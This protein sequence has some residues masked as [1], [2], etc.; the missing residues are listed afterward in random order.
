MSGFFPQPE[1]DYP[2]GAFPES[3]FANNGHPPVFREAIDRM[4]ALAP[5]PNDTP[6][7]D[8]FHL[9]ME[10]AALEADNQALKDTIDRLKGELESANT[11]CA[12]HAKG[13][14]WNQEHAEQLREQLAQNRKL[15]ATLNDLLEDQ[16]L[17]LEHALRALD[18]I[19]ELKLPG[20]DAY[21]VQYGLVGAV[22]FLQGIA[23]AGSKNTPLEDVK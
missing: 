18:I 13:E 14:L 3:L 9:T 2:P 17:R 21:V 1:G 5:T 16:G 19:A 23:T 6:G 7:L 12:L 10:K 15:S 22:Q 8:I 11:L 4:T 20:G